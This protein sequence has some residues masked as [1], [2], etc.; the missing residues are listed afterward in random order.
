MAFNNP[1]LFING[2]S[3]EI[4]ETSL[5]EH[6]NKYGEV[7][8]VLIIALKNIG[9]VT[10]FDPSMAQNALQ[11]EHIILGR[12]VEVKS[13]KPKVSINDR[14]IFVGGLPH[15]ITHEDFT[16]YFDAFGTITDAVIVP[17]SQT[18]ISRG[19]GFVTYD[20]EEAVKRVLKN[21]CHSEGEAGEEFC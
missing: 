16:Q 19:F 7:K 10:F 3:S 21:R 15:A 4:T 5:K 14:K 6:F 8:E 1:K 11:H 17:N 20:S 13:A 9:F 2:V 18:K 12:K